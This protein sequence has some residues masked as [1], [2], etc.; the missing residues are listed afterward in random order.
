MG[1]HGHSVAS[2][3]K[4]AALA[5]HRPGSPGAGAVLESVR[6]VL[7]QLPEMICGSAASKSLTKVAGGMM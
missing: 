5:A 6:A 3:S 1:K 2:A 4:R 7:A